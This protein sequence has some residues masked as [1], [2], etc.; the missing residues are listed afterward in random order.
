MFELK[1]KTLDLL[2]NIGMFLIIFIGTSQLLQNSIAAAGEEKSFFSFFGENNNYKNKIIFYLKSSFYII[3]FTDGVKFV[4][5]VLLSSF[6]KDALLST[7]APS[8]VQTSISVPLVQKVEKKAFSSS[9]IPDNYYERKKSESHV[10]IVKKTILFDI[11]QCIISAMSEIS[12]YLAKVI[13][14]LIIHF[15]YCFNT[16]TNWA[17]SFIFYI[18]RSLF[19]AISSIALV[20]LHIAQILL[21]TIRRGYNGVEYMLSFVCTLV[22]D[23]SLISIDVIRTTAINKEEQLFKDLKNGELTDSLGLIPDGGSDGNS[24][25]LT[26]SDT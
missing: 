6:L 3:N 11:G 12:Y 15:Q 26:L 25:I 7:V 24:D 2:L 13:V 5:R 4:S 21:R 8:H 20:A 19:C 1:D 22:N 14:K 18:G 10:A 9:W 16:L 23:A 17:A